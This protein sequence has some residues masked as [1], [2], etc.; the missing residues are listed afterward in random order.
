MLQI[1]NERELRVGYEILD[2]LSDRERLGDLSEKLVQHIVETKRA[3]R[4]YTHRKDEDRR[5]V[6][7]NGIDGYVCLERLP[8][9][10][11]DQVD[12]IDYFR[13]FREISYRPSAYDCTG[14]AFTM[15]YKVFQRNGRFF[16]YHCIC[17]D[18]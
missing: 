6:K 1:R 10:L 3:I 7:D 17:F 8:E 15:W 14:Q 5:I 12:A 11:E 18:V 4:A 2:L 16:A 13:S 9:H